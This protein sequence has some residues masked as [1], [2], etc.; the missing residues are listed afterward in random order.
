MPTATPWYWA[1]SCP[2]GPGSPRTARASRYRH[3]VGRP[4]KNDKLAALSASGHLTQERDWCS[5]PPH[6]RIAANDWQC[7]PTFCPSSLC[8]F[9]CLPWLDYPRWFATK[10]RCAASR[11]Q[12]CRQWCC[13][14]R[15]VV[16][17]RIDRDLKEIAVEKIPAFEP[18]QEAMIGNLAF[19]DALRHDNERAKRSTVIHP[20][21]GQRCFAASVLGAGCIGLRVALPPKHRQWVG[22]IRRHP[23]RCGRPWMMAGAGGMARAG[24]DHE[25]NEREP[26][27]DLDPRTIRTNRGR[28]HY[29]QSQT[30]CH[31]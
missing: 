24:G 5:L 7:A 29:G 27:S 1:S 6:A 13:R 3:C 14:A 11:P 22:V 20:I 18:L 23:A 9:P 31:R 4:R 26:L 8:C 25:S 15:S 30:H 12:D 10:G 17:I 21:V 19:F 2:P 16:S 28:I